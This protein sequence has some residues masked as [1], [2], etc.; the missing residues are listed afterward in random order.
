MPNAIRPR[1]IV[2]LI[3]LTAVPLMT[4]NMFIPSLSVM[5]EDFEVGY[6]TMAL[7]ISLYLA[8]SAVIQIVAGPLADTYGRRPVL[9][10]GLLVFVLAS[11]GCALATE[12]WLFLVFRLLQGAVI[13]GSVLSRAIVNDLASPRQAASVLGYIAMAMSLAPIFGPTLGGLLG[14]SLGWRSNFWV[15]VFAG[16]GLWLLVLIL[17]PETANPDGRADRRQFFHSYHTLLTSGPFWAY[18][19]IMSFSVGVFY[20]FIS[21]VPL[22]AGVQLGM[23]QFEV[24]LGIGSITVG[25]M[26]GSFVSGKLPTSVSLNI[27]LKTGR[28]IASAG[29]LSSLLLVFAGW[30]SPWALFGGTVLVGFGN[31]LTMPSANSLAMSLHPHWAASAAGVSGAIIVLVGAV[32]STITGLVLEV[33]PTVSTLQMLMLVPTLL[34]LLIAIWVTRLST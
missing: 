18:S 9:L 28:Y 25:F 15:Y 16:T 10:A 2:T 23:N 19:M 1:L 11:I 31:G 24:G 30:I 29:L 27:M 7:A 5:A 34:G 17:L 26:L 6:D 3:L 8:F 20:V 12:Y 22:V 13:S 14:E 32:L 21:G 33:S 4:L